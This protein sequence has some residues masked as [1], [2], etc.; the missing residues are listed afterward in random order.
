MNSQILFVSLALVFIFVAG[1]NATTITIK[2]N[3]QRTIWPATLTGDQKPQLSTTGF[4]LAPGAT[5]S[6]DIPA[7]TW[8]G[9]FWG[10]DR[11]STDA[12]GRF[13]CATGDCGSGRV[14]CNG[15]SG[16]PPA[17]LIELTIGGDGGKDFYD[18]SNVDG[19]NVP[20]SVAPQGGSGECQQSSCP[21]N[22]NDACLAE[23]QY[24]S[25]NDV[26][27]CLSACTKFNE[28]RYCC[29]GAFDKPETC[30]PTDYSNFFEQK[31]PQAYSYAYDDKTS[32]FTC[33]GSN[34][35]ITFC[36]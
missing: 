1:A 8:T 27:G 23:L 15:L 31:C 17:T 10:R 30:P 32:T 16:A 28:D 6:V 34:Y 9:R 5:Q 22:I 33:T 12:S 35:L 25:G 4:E 24:K 26:V 11:C 29:R 18:V 14:E 7:G 2:N 3:C 19:F 21:V 36:P 13:M 20:A